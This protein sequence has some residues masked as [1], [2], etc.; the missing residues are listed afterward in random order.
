MKSARTLCVLALRACAI[1]DLACAA[2]CTTAVIQLAGG[3]ELDDAERLAL[4]LRASAIPSR[5]IVI[6]QQIVL[7]SDQ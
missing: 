6:E 3:L 5:V 2:E 4:L 7:P 1:V